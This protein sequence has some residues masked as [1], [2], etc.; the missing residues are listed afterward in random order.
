MAENSKSRR[1]EVWKYF[2]TIETNGKP[3]KVKCSLCS[4]ELSYA[5]GS[6]G[7]MTNHIKHVHKSL[8]LK[9]H[10]SLSSS[11]TGAIKKQATITAFRS[12]VFTREKWIVCT[13]KLAYMCAR[14]LR[15]ISICEREG[16]KAFCKELNPAYDVP[17]ATTISKYV[18]KLYETEKTDLVNLIKKQKGVALTS[19]HWTSLAT[20]GYIT[21]TGHFIDDGNIDLGSEIP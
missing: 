9:Q 7:T 10:H 20:E 17:C 2:S 3:I 18:S 12:P 16:F 14:D 6:T 11:D 8:N 21:V 1:S 13:Q 15:S 4:C 5:G 19:D